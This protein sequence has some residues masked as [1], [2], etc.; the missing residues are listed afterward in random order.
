MTTAGPLIVN[1][2]LKG[3]GSLLAKGLPALG[4]FL[5]TAIGRLGVGGVGT[6]VGAGVG[7]AGAVWAGKEAKKDWETGHKGR[8][9]SFGLGALGMGAGAATLGVVAIA[10]AIGLAVAPLLG[11]I[12]WAL[13][14]IG[15]AITGITVIWKKY[16]DNIKKWLSPLGEFMKKVVDF[17]AIVNPIFFVIKKTMEWLQKVWPWG[18][19]D[20]NN[21]SSSQNK[22]FMDKVK[23]KIGGFFSKDKQDEEAV[24]SI[25][26]MSINKAG[27]MIGIRSMDRMSASE[28]V[29]EY[30]SSNPTQFNRAYETVGSKYAYLSSFTNDLAIRDKSGRAQQAVLYKGAG[31]ELEYLWSALESGGMQRNRAQLLKYTSGRAT[32]SS[33]HKRGK[34]NSH[35]NIM[36]MVTDLGVA[37]QWSDQEW[38]TAFEVLKPLMAQQGFD[39]KYEGVNSKGKTIYGDKFVGGLSNR[40]FHVALAKGTEKALPQSSLENVKEYEEAQKAIAEQ[41]SIEAGSLLYRQDSEALE[42]LNKKLEGKSQEEINRAYDKELKKWDIEYDPNAQ[43]IEGQKGLW[44]VVREGEKQGIV[45]IDPTGNKDFANA[46]IMLVQLTNMGS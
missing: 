27:G 20:E 36:N 25:K 7:I 44:T 3:I 23:D 29:K 12:G 1:L 8:A 17:L 28:A 15:A 42:R 46:E 26:G 9:T 11:P 40:H 38:E 14:G 4:R 18:N 34:A 41:H 31:E 30:M 6:L 19:K 35:D 10:K 22:K 39:L 24:S 33:G 21:A 2:L 43:S 45:A 5:G 37:N 16:G 13:L 32:A